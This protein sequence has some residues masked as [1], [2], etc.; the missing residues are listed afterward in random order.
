MPSL[1]PA[2]A[3]QRVRSSS[4][5]VG[6]VVA[7]VVGQH[8]VPAVA[9]V[10]APIGH[11]VA[12]V[13]SA[14]LP[15][16]SNQVAATAT[17]D[18]SDGLLGVCHIDHLGSRILAAMR[19]VAGELRGRRIIAPPGN[20]T[21]PT[22]DKVR[23]AVFNALES[24]GLIDGAVVVDL[25]AGSGAMGIEALSR[26]AA[27]C[28]FV[29][30]DRAALAAL[31]TNLDALQVVDR[32]KV[33]VGDATAQAPH[34]RNIDLVIADPPYLFDGWEALLRSIDAPDVIAE[35][36]REIVPSGGWELVRARR[37]GR[38]VITW[39]QRVA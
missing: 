18:T 36:D 31:R 38:T 8:E 11:D 17:V 19:V 14:V 28:T 33:V 3:Q 22:S 39:L 16:G 12:R 37:Y 34:L 2:G 23:Q 5:L 13:P 15:R 25:F 7:P 30:R 10:L 27:S 20:D 32:S 26:G 24:A 9:A 35:S 1:V 4:P 29:E 21:R 6:G